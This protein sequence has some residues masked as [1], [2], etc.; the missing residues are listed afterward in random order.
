MSIQN[1][2]KKINFADETILEQVPGLKAPNNKYGFETEIIPIEELVVLLFLFIEYIY[3]ENNKLKLRMDTLR[4]QIF[5]LKIP[6]EK[7]RFKYK[8]A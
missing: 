3:N 6:V 4:G 7:L 5:T 1:I 8:V 2:Y